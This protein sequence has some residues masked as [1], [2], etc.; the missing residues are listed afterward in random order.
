M[1]GPN[2]KKL[3]IRKMAT[4]AIPGGGGLADGIR[5]LSDPQGLSKAARA[6]TEWVT[7]AIRAVR[8]AA[9]PNPWKA[10]TDEDIAGEILRK[11]EANQ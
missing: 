9:E 5:F 4:D 10:A 6:A 3:I 7:V 2:V 1:Q 8:E 11:I